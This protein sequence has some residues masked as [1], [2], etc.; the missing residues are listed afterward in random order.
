MRLIV[1]QCGHTMCG[2]S[3]MPRAFGARGVISRPAPLAA[4][5]R[6]YPGVTADPANRPPSMFISEPVM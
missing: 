6:H 3:D 1:S 2:I 4:E 5:A